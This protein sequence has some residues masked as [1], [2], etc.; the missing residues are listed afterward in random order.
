MTVLRQSAVVRFGNLRYDSHAVA[1][2]ADLVLLPGT[3]AI[4]C[5]LPA[6]VRVDAS[7]GDPAVVTLGNGETEATVLTGTVQSISRAFTGT[8]ITAVDGAALMARGRPASTLQSQPP[9]DAIRAL[10]G[11]VAA[12]VGRVTL[13]PE[14]L[15]YYAATQQR[16]AAEH[17]AALAEIGGGLAV[18]DGDG[19][20]NAFLRPAGTADAAL[21]YGRELV[22]LRVS[23]ERPDPDVA[24]VG[25]GAAATAGDPRALQPAAGALSGDA[26]SAAV[27]MVWRPIPALRT[28]AS[29]QAA[30]RELQARR[31]ARVRRLLAV[32]WL[33]P[34]LRPGMLIEI[35]D[36]PRGFA[37]GPWLLTAVSH[38]LD[39]AGGYTRLEGVDGGGGAGGLAGAIGGALGAAVGGAI[40]G[41]PGGLS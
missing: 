15:P 10:A 13:S 3:N 29:R 22:D 18:V 2:S 36:L 25:A 5:L 8:G 23:V 26:R 9:G 17:V 38:Q 30:G 14:P 32:C 41:A 19:R 12:T 4:R 20:V 24:V 1:V 11:D 27:D 33:Q 35:Q 31:S 34:Q 40:G 21:R 7:P 28:P 37:G 39:R 16:T 6:A